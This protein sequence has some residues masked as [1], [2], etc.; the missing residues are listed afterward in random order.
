LKFLLGAL[1][2]KEKERKNLQKKAKRKKVHQKRK[3]HQ[4]RRKKV[5]E[6]LPP[7][8]EENQVDLRIKK[9]ERLIHNLMNYI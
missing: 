2:E 8:K 7:K 1:E 4:K 6:N 9:L 3:N 5:K